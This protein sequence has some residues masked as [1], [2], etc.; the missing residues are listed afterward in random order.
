MDDMKLVAMGNKTEDDL[1]QALR[2][3]ENPVDIGTV[4][5]Y[6]I[7]KDYKQ[8]ERMDI[9]RLILNRFSTD[10]LIDELPEGELERIRKIIDKI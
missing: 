2:K 4:L 5:M 1:L 10:F 7:A 6:Y 8:E 3:I 9:I